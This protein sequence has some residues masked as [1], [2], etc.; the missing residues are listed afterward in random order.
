[1][2]GVH[3]DEGLAVLVVVQNSANK[4][5]PLVEHPLEQSINQR[6]A[7]LCRYLLLVPTLD[8]DRVAAILR[9]EVSPYFASAAMKPE[10]TRCTTP[11]TGGDSPAAS[12]SVTLLKVFI[13][14]ISLVVRVLSKAMMYV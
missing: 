4:A 5:A 14:K 3:E 7:D 6:V 13:H 12:T 11:C 10:T 9:V 8:E 2:R 1:M